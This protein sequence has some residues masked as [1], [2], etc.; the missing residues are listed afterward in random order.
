MSRTRDIR[1]ELKLPQGP[2]FYSLKTAGNNYALSNR[3]TTGPGRGD[4]PYDNAWL[5]RRNASCN[6]GSY[7]TP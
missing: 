7:S 2:T 5:S 3:A 1:S 6:M 4:G